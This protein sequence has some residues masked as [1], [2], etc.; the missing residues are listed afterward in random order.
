MGPQQT[1]ALAAAL[2][3]RMG[4]SPFT[5]LEQCVCLYTY[6]E[7]FGSHKCGIQR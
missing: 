6:A 4:R 2:Q 7:F 1:A 3:G 5:W